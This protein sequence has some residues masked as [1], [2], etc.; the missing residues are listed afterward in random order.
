MDRKDL[1]LSFSEGWRPGSARL[2]IGNASIAS[3]VCRLANRARHHVVATMYELHNRASQFKF[4][5]RLAVSGK[6][7]AS[8]IVACLSRCRKPV[9]LILDRVNEPVGASG[10]EEGSYLEKLQKAG[11]VRIFYDRSLD[12]PPGNKILAFFY[13]GLGVL[14]DRWFRKSSSLHFR[15]FVRLLDIFSGHSNHK[16]VVTADFG[17]QAIVSSYNWTDYDENHSNVG[18]LYDGPA[19]E[20]T[21]YGQLADLREFD[22]RFWSEQRKRDSKASAGKSLL[23]YVEQPHLRFYADHFFNSIEAGD[24]VDL[25]FNMFYDP[26]LIR[27]IKE[28]CRLGAFFRILLDEKSRYCD[29]KVPHLLNYLTWKELNGVPNASVRFVRNPKRPFGEHHQKSALIH[30]PGRKVSLAW[31]GSPNLTTC[32]LDRRSFR[33]TALLIADTDFVEAY[34]DYFNKLWRSDKVF[35]LQPRSNLFLRNY[36]Y[37]FNLAA[38]HLGIVPA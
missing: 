32:V 29:I 16:K 9:Y 3:A 18:V 37:V 28:K 30:K 25:V 34:G 10:V 8:R 12:C 22:R 24:R 20:Q 35:D 14:L 38:H 1:N 33:D 13:P 6:T 2:L 23:K 36:E 26:R 7:N 11:R 31:V 19:A 15:K 5:T 27:I 17:S 21:F 4:G